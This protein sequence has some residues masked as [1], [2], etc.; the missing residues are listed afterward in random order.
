MSEESPSKRGPLAWMALH[1][2][3]ANL[4]MCMLIIGGLFVATSVTQEVFPELPEDAVTVTATYPGADPVQVERAVLD[5]MEQAISGLDSTAD[6]RA[7]V[8]EGY[9][10]LEVRFLDGIA[11]DRGLEE[12]ER[13]LE[14][15]DT[16]PDEME[17]PRIEIPVDRSEAITVMVHGPHADLMGLKRLSDRIS[18]ELRQLPEITAIEPGGLR[19][20]E[21][22]ID[23]DP[24]RIKEVGLTRDEIAAIIKANMR[25]MPGGSLDTSG[26]EVLVRVGTR[27][28][29]AHELSKIPLKARA[30][31]SVIRVED[32]AEVDD[33]FA[34]E[35]SRA[36]YN[37]ERAVR[38]DVYRVGD[39][40]PLEIARRVKTYV[41]ERQG[42]L[43]QGYHI[44]IWDDETEE[45]GA[46]IGLLGRNAAQG[47]VLVLVVLG[48]FLSARLSFWVTLG[49]PIS[50]LGGMWLLPVSDVSINMISLFGFIL[51]LGIVVDD[52]IVVGEAIY[53]KREEHDSHVDAA[54]AGVRSVGP[55]VVFS[56]LT[57]VTAFLPLLFV[58]EH[59]GKFFR[60]IPTIVIPILLLSLVEA[61]L[62]L[63]A[64]L[65]HGAKEP[66]STWRIWFNEKIARFV[67]VI[68]CPLVRG[69]VRWRW[70]TLGFHIGLLLLA[71]GLV[72]GRHLKYTFLP[73]IE[74][75]F[76]LAGVDMP[77][78]TSGDRTEDAMKDLVDAAYAVEAEYGARGSMIRG[79]YSRVGRGFRVPEGQPE[80]GAHLS[81]VAVKLV[82]PG[83]RPMTTEA[84]S[85]QWR[86]KLGEVAGASRLIFD[87]ASG[88]L[89]SDGVSLELRHADEDALQRASDALATEL[90]RTP[91]VFNVEDGRSAGKP[92]LIITLNARGES[93]GVDQREIGRQVRSAFLGAEAMRIIRGR[94]EVRVMVRRALRDR[95]SVAEIKEMPVRLSRGRG[96]VELGDIAEISYE[97]GF[98]QI[99]HINGERVRRIEAHV[100]T[101]STSSGAVMEMLEQGAL[102]DLTARFPGLRYDEGGGQK[103]Q[104]RIESYLMRSGAMAFIVMFALMAVAFGS[105]TQPLIIMTAIPFGVIGAFAGH[106][107]LG[108][109]L[110]LVSILGIV[111]LSGV[112]VNDALVLI[113]AVNERREQAPKAQVLDAVIDGVARRFRPIILTTLTTFFGLLPMMFETSTQA[114]FLVP[115]A[116]SL[117][118]GILFV[119]VIVLA[120]VP[121]LYVIIDDA[122]QALSRQPPTE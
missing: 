101:G 40:R 6:I 36:Y 105:Y 60:A 28:D 49:I 62:I 96:V 118:C 32:I 19:P 120:L 112:V 47:L 20:P 24:R 41:A 61:L 22:H 43:P 26:G 108:F 104:R 37:G 29:A 72:K 38:L 5:P 116:I 113:V 122:K 75:N 82:E 58:P 46:R 27:R 73:N 111:A 71:I 9:V 59:T 103:S 93:L 51:V 99:T 76:A 86:A 33:G 94:D 16:F 107:L 66:M 74:S 92:Q 25:Q 106:V 63:P 77:L 7:V 109:D 85:R 65:A 64:H 17:R 84:F 119:T 97:Q 55:P 114:R 3:A 13:A 67:D 121:S 68:V 11:V 89:G 8:S 15:V 78:G 80:R 88:P 83:G 39:E 81:F 53:A 31:G 54:I 117:G 69:A 12:V 23:I 14:R 98:S 115:M 44:S 79:V 56:V 30:N 50:F 10:W 1:P 70:A 87:Y 110:S 42:T 2:V 100:D 35:T 57:T 45:F 102:P 48:L 4:L 91:G 21:V 34:E 52:A 90:E 95:R 18:D